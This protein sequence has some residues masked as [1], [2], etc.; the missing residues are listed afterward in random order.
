MAKSG[1]HLGGKLGP[2]VARVV[3]DA[4]A[5]HLNKTAHTRA[6]IE[7]EAKHMFWRDVERERDVHVSPLLSRLL[8]HEDTHPSVEKALQFMHKGQG[9]LAG[10]LATR[11]TSTVLA[12]GILS[13]VANEL[14]PINQRLIALQPNTLLEPGQLAQLVQGGLLDFQTALAEAERG[15][16]NGYRFGLLREL[17]VQYPDAATLLELL[18]RGFTDPDGV[19][20]TLRR[21]GYSDAAARE[22]LQLR[23][24]VL[25]PPDLALMRLRG[26]ID[27][28]TGRTIAAQSGVDAEDFDRLV[29]ATGEPPGL[30]QLL[31]A[32]RRGFIPKD[33]LDRGIRQSR[34]RDEWIDVVERLRFE[35]MA[36]ADAVEA[37]VRNIITDQQGRAIAEQNGLEL[38]QWPALV[39]A[40]GRPPGLGQ[41]Q[42]L[43]NRGLVSQAQVDQAVRE[44]DIKDKYVDL[45][46]G[47]RVRIPAERLVVT[48]LQHGAITDARAH[49][50]L[51]KDGYEA[52]V[53]GSILRTGA[54][55]RTAGHK[56]EAVGQVTELYE[57]H[58]IDQARAASMVEALGYP[59][60]DVPLLLR[61]AEL[62]R[63]RK[64]R[65]QAAGA[66]RSA[67]LKRHLDAN[68]A[69]AELAAI[70]LPSAQVEYLLRLWAIELRG[71]RKQL[72]EAQ[73][74]HA[75]RFGAID[76]A[77]TEVRLRN[78][79][80]TDADAALLVA[81]AG[82]LPKGR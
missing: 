81:T 28:Q 55:Q 3:V 2:R 34:V 71:T 14:A 39:A 48:M 73:I 7:A 60:A 69:A 38:S 32:Y 52:D 64:E 22:L 19:V 49:E 65:E 42:A 4:Q 12:Q 18:R 44:S 72:S 16:I 27:D 78:L 10:I 80:Y 59:K 25:A 82:P 36:T 50:L 11:A 17:A 76:R 8:G 57:D 30:E 53:A 68:E 56:H 24:V 47:L 26:I 6:R 31:E 51:L 67:Y 13:G 62:K 21:L 54:A 45:V 41:M 29:L 63:E 79:G 15:G 37:V 46:R 77:D 23:R 70:G 43:L 61:L 5:D 35:P 9:E 75:H 33:R 40:H 66:V 74:V 20:T 58:A 1:D